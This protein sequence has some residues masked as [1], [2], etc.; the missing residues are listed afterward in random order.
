L[1]SL[2]AEKVKQ[3]PKM[4]LGQLPILVEF[5]VLVLE[6]PASVWESQ[7]LVLASDAILKLEESKGSGQ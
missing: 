7:R 2:S 4:L 3:I 5:E 1:L 6:L